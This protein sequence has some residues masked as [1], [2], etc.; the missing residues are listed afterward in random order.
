MFFRLIWKLFNTLRLSSVPH[1]IIITYTYRM[2]RRFLN[3][4]FKHQLTFFSPLDGVCQLDVLD[5]PKQW[6]TIVDLVKLKRTFTGW[7][8]INVKNIS[9]LLDIINIM[10]IND[11]TIYILNESTKALYSVSP[12]CS[13]KFAYCYLERNE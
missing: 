3:S 12:F 4:F 7:W 8:I 10:F 2:V 5:R 13:V 6:L 9:K 1:L 11:I